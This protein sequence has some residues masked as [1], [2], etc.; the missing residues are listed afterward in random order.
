[1]HMLCH[2]HGLLYDQTQTLL[3]LIL[4]KY[5]KAKQ[6]AVSFEFIYYEL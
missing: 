4:D 6:A 2:R 5:N 3:A 1:M